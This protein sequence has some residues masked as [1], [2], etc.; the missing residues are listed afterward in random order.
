MDCSMPGF[1][2]LHHLLELMSIESV[3][4]YNHLILFFP[5]FLLTSIFPNIRIFSNESVHCIRG[6]KYWSFSFSINLSEEYSGL[7]FFKIDWFDNFSVQGI[8]KSLLQLT[9]FFCTLFDY[10]SL[11]FIVLRFLQTAGLW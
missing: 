8:L 7:I 10:A 11:R 6:P 1:S 4:L 3:M 5:L 2:I 9:A